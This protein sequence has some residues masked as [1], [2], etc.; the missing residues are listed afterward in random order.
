MLQVTKEY[1]TL[2]QV[3]LCRRTTA[4]KFSKADKQRYTLFSIPMSYIRAL[5]AWVKDQIF[6]CWG[7][8]LLRGR[9]VAPFTEPLLVLQYQLC[10]LRFWI[11][12]EC[13]NIAHFHKKLQKFVKNTLY[14]AWGCCTGVSQ[15]NGGFP[16]CTFPELLIL[17]SLPTKGEQRRR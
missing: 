8:I 11:V 16:P 5:I 2:T 7:P 17:P 12:H 6:R 14:K 15:A 13:R 3:K 1:H 10:I 9:S 4:P